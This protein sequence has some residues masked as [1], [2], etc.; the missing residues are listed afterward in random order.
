MPGA[1]ARWGSPDVPARFSP[2]ILVPRNLI[3]IR[4][5]PQSQHQPIRRLVY[6]S[7]AAGP[8][9]KVDHADILQSSRVNNALDGITGLLWSD[10]REYV[11]VIEGAEGAVNETFGKIRVDPRHCDVAILSDHTGMER[12]FAYWTMA[13]IDTAE[14]AFK[15]RAHLDRFMQDAPEEV[16]R[17]F[18]TRQIAG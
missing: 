18:Q 3:Y 6:T 2:A 9:R 11:Q 17:A 13:T 7:V 5:V 10:G 14:D 4:L 16:R 12:A 1:A 8:S 15:V